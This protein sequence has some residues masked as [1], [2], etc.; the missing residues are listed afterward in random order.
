MDP[1]AS[2]LSWSTIAAET[3]STA[4]PVSDHNQD[5]VVMSMRARPRVTS[6]GRIVRRLV[7]LAVFTFPGGHY[8]ELPGIF[9]DDQNVWAIVCDK[10]PRVVRTSEV[11][12]R[13]VT[14]D[15]N[16][17]PCRYLPLRRCGAT[18]CG[19][20]LVYESKAETRRG[21]TCGRTAHRPPPLFT[22]T[23]DPKNSLEYNFVFN[24]DA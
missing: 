9:V 19:A 15:R 21:V 18:K 16:H 3:G 10:C 7:R 6:A 4:E 8:I 5:W 17:G 2:T 11:Y 22:G 13:H 14:C 1:F 24:G 23:R 12:G 20:L